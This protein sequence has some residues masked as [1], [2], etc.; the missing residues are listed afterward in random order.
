MVIELSF[1]T[2]YGSLGV[3]VC[4]ISGVQGEKTKK[5]S[6]VLLWTREASLPLIYFSCPTLDRG[7]HHYP[8]KIFYLI[9]NQHIS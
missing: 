1:S 2:V 8:Q 5:A 6:L 7:R 3:F 9:F 4:P